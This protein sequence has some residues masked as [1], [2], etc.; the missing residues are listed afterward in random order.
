MDDRSL[1]AA[2][3]KVVLLANIPPI[4]RK[5]FCADL[6]KQYK[7][8]H[9]AGSKWRRPQPY[10]WLKPIIGRIAALQEDLKSL[11]VDMRMEPGKRLMETEERRR[12]I[13]VV[14]TRGAQTRADCDAMFA[15]EDAL[16]ALAQPWKT[17]PQVQHL[18]TAKRGRGA[19]KEPSPWLPGARA[20]E[21]CVD[22]SP[23]ARFF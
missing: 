2:C 21:T 4:T 20:A 13:A 19:L 8:L 11:G 7:G 3:K 12:L 9:R 14:L 1:A 16:E 10:A 18:Q 17:L 23:V 22:G 5:L 6:V 15:F